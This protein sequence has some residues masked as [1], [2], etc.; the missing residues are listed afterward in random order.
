MTIEPNTLVWAVGCGA[1]LLIVSIAAIHADAKKNEALEEA[2]NLRDQLESQRGSSSFWRKMYIRRGE[3][4]DKLRSLLRDVATERDRAKAYCIESDA[5]RE[6]MADDVHR[7]AVETK[8]LKEAIAAAGAANSEL[9]DE[10]TMLKARESEHQSVLDS[11]NKAANANR[12][13]A[14]GAEKDVKELRNAVKTLEREKERLIARLDKHKR[15]E[16]LPAH[17]PMATLQGT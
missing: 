13:R 2:D 3:E 16:E 1:M 12:R 4:A 8:R 6:T 5:Q 14:E 17:L 10:I 15:G 11:V 9:A 7:L